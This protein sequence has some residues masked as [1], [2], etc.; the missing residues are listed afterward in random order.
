M[1]THPISLPLQTY[2]GNDSEKRQRA[3]DH[4]RRVRTVESYVNTA[5]PKLG[6]PMHCFHAMDIEKETGLSGAAVADV[7]AGDNGITVCK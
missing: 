1:Q 4:N 2:S 3:E 5:F 7:L 6:K